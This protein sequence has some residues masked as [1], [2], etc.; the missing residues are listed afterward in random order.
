MSANSNQDLILAATKSLKLRDIQLF[1]SRFERPAADIE[2]E[3]V[4]A[5]QQHKK[6]VSAAVG[7]AEIGSGKVKLFQATVSFGT[8]VVSNGSKETKEPLV[9]FLI[10][11]D[12][13]VEYE[14]NGDVPEDALKA[15]AQFNCIHNAWPFWRQHVFDIAQRGRLPQLDIPLLP[16]MKIA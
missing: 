9:L 12:F 14:I 10:E 8:R 3:T 16:G 13:L 1:S 5:E 15:F 7:E 4:K 2:P 11:A 6:T